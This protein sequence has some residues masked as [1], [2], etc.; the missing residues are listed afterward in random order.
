MAS[1]PKCKA[2]FRNAARR[3]AVSASSSES[4][5]LRAENA[6]DGSTSSR[7]GSGWA[8]EQWISVRLADEMRISSVAVLWE[9]ALPQTYH[10]QARALAMIA[11][12][13]VSVGRVCQ[14]RV[15]QEKHTCEGTDVLV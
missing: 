9:Q 10:V 1:A 2:F 8:D 3:A 12:G 13:R 5:E 4:D 7:W 14:M 6:V 15:L 11:H